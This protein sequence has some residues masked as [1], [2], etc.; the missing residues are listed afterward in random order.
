M[1]EAHLGQLGRQNIGLATGE[2]SA[3]CCALDIDSEEGLI[4]FLSV[5]PAAETWPRLVGARGAKLLVRMEGEYP[6]KGPLLLNGEQWGD[7]LSTGSLAIVQGI[8]P[9]TRKPYEWTVQAKVQTVPF[10]LIE[11][12]LSALNVQRGSV[13]HR[14]LSPN[15]YNQPSTNSSESCILNPTPCVLDTTSCILHNKEA[16]ESMVARI[17]A[18]NELRSCV[19]KRLGRLEKLFE[20]YIE[21]RFEAAAGNRNGSL[22]EAIPYLIRCVSPIV[23]LELVMMFYHTHRQLFN[24]PP[25]QHKAEANAMIEGVESTYLD[26]LAVVEHS[27]FNELDEHCRSAFRICRDLA[28]RADSQTPLVFFM[29]CNELAARLQIHDMQASRLLRWFEELGIIS[30]VE[31]GERRQQ[32][33]LTKASSYRWLLGTSSLG[34]HTEGGQTK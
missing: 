2:P 26:E 21:G 33:K 28:Y 34:T 17:K 18:R 6:K 12:A 24:D 19:G 9:D 23:A 4:Q 1:T 25:E 31:K 15:L 22:V 7:W 5:C 14:L 20:N 27:V 11:N 16:T 13:K 10:S 32:G 8:H 3:G 30:L 29:A